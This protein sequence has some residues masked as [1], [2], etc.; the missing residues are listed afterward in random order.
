ME[1]DA[2]SNGIPFDGNPVETEPG[3]LWW[4]GWLSSAGMAQLF[5]PP[6]GTMIDG[7]VLEV[8]IKRTDHDDVFALQLG[9]RP[10]TSATPAA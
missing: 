5:N 6:P 7:A 9:F 10:S 3:L 1:T 4:K 8:R 2:R